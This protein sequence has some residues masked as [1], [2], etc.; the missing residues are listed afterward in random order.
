M[1]GRFKLLY[2]ILSSNKQKFSRQRF[3]SAAIEVDVVKWYGSIEVKNASR[4]FDQWR[5]KDECV[6]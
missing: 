6:R 2:R 3:L 1:S 4:I 5:I